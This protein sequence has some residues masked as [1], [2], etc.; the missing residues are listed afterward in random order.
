MRKIIVANIAR[1]LFVNAY[2]CAAEEGTLPASF[3]RAKSQQNWFDIAPPTPKSAEEAA[4]KL[5]TIIE[6]QSGLALEEA[7]E[8]AVHEQ[9][10]LKDPTL[11]GFGYCLAM[12]ALGSGVGWADDHPDHELKIP[13]IEAIL[14]FD[15]ANPNNLDILFTSGL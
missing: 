13:S 1:A 5:A 14:D 4:E 7:Y 8:I 12:E 11:E 10:H 3:P 2:S 15:P 9:G 6:S